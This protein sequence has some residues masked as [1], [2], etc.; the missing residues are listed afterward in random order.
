MTVEDTEQFTVGRPTSEPADPKDSSDAAFATVRNRRS[1][2]LG[3]ALGAIVAVF[4]P[5]L[6]APASRQLAIYADFSSER[7]I[8]IRAVDIVS[9][10][11]TTFDRVQQGGNQVAASDDGRFVAYSTASDFRVLDLK[12][13]AVRRLSPFWAGTKFSGAFITMTGFRPGGGLTAYSYP[14]ERGVVIEGVRGRWRPRFEYRPE[15]CP[16]MSGGCEP[17]LSWISHDL[18]V[19]TPCAEPNCDR[20]RMEVA[21]VIGKTSRVVYTEEGACPIGVLA[22][23]RLAYLTNCGSTSPS[24]LAILSPEDGNHFS[25]RRTGIRGDFTLGDGRRRGRL[26][27]IEGAAN[28]DSWPTMYVLDVEGHLTKLGR[29]GGYLGLAWLPDRGVAFT[30]RGGI[31]ALDLRG[32]RRVITRGRDLRLLA[33]YRM[34]R[35]GVTIR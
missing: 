5:L 24:E 3:V 8:S 33:G 25:S 32:E 31:S 14:T 23:R 22:G 20:R 15:F 2:V 12:Q 27:A 17:V 7:Y 16:P 18:V 19:R 11:T 28:G 4:A 34:K 35:S 21:R 6:T 29:S 9:G 26:F 13:G 30:E 1:F 10:H